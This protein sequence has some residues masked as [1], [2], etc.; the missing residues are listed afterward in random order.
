MYLGYSYAYPNYDLSIYITDSYKIK[1]NVICSGIF[2]I[3][4]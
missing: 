2:G 3:K 4:L 1:R